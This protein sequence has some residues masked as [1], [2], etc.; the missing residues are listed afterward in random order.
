MILA[1]TS[2]W[3]VISYCL[4]N[5]L[6]ENNVVVVTGKAGVGKT[7]LVL[8]VIKKYSEENGYQLLCVKNRSLE[9]YDDLVSAT[10][11]RGKYLFFIDDANEL[12]QLNLIAEY[13]TKEELGYDIKIIV[14]VR[15]YV[16]DDVIDTI[17]KYTIPY[18]INIQVFTDDEIQEFLK[19]NLEIFNQN[20][21]DQIIKIAEGNPRIAYMAGKIAVDNQSLSSI[22]NAYELYDSYYKS[23]VKRTIGSNQKLCFVAGL[24][25][26]LKKLRLDDCSSFQVLLDDYGITI[27]DFKNFIIELSDCEVVEIHYDLIVTISDECFFNYMLYYVFFEKKMI[28]FSRVFPSL[29]FLTMDF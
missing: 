11:D 17:K 28:P 18:T 9:I 22:N 1:A 5:G 10:T 20:Y 6:N 8:E 21:L 4:L 26:I 25:A 15:D 14:T 12:P 7:R 19:I 24:L 23:Y 27:D 29:E 3:E 2:Y 16:K 13:I